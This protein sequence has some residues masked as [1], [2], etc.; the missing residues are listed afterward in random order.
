MDPFD[1][2]TAEEIKA[3]RG[4][5]WIAIVV[6]ILGFAAAAGFGGLYFLNYYEVRLTKES[7]G[8]SE[9]RYSEEAT[10]LN[11]TI[12]RLEGELNSKRDANEILT[13]QIKDEKNRAQQEKNRAENLAEKIETLEKT[14]EDL[15]SGDQGIVRMQAKLA[16]SEVRVS[17]LQEEIQRTRNILA[18]TQS[19][20][21]E[22]ANVNDKLEKD[23]KKTGTELR[24]AKEMLASANVTGAAR[25]VLESQLKD[26][27]KQIDDLKD[28][29]RK[30]EDELQRKDGELGTLRETIGKSGQ[31]TA[32]LQK[33]MEELSNRDREIGR[34]DAEI[35][36]L[37]KEVE[38]LEKK[39]DDYERETNS[40]RNTLAQR[41]DVSEQVKSLSEAL[42]G[43]DQIIK[44]KDEE[45]ATLKEKL[46][47]SEE[48]AEQTSESGKAETTELQK[49]LV[50]KTGFIQN[51]EKQVKNLQQ[52][53]K[54][55]N[56]L[57]KTE[58]RS[59]EK[60][61]KGEEAEKVKF[62]SS[63][64]RTS[65]EMSIQVTDGSVVPDKIDLDS[66]LG[67][68]MNKNSL[69]LEI[70]ASGRFG[71]MLDYQELTFSGRNVMTANRN[72]FNNTLNAGDTVDSEFYIQQPGLGLLA[73][74][75]ALHKSET[76]RIDLGLLLGGR[77]LKVN[78]RILD[79]TTGVK[80]TDTLDAPL[81]Y[82]G[83]KV[84]GTYRD[85]VSWSVQARTMNFNYGDYS[86]RNYVEGRVAFGF[87]LM[88]S[89]D[90]D[91]GYAYAN[92]NYKRLDKDTGE[93][94][95][96]KHTSEGPFF[97]VVLTF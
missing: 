47:T 39:N 66:D 25:D 43:R 48:T 30:N 15:R 79:R 84:S 57:L 23:L 11:E 3:M 45:M 37:A 72:F 53:N 19:R 4:T 80:S 86:L 2:M 91:F 44:K 26:K 42:A 55:I 52:E 96:S 94:F 28:K 16:E 5:S 64:W 32:E 1:R 87:N 22:A 18:N 6:A 61:D 93:S 50:E 54:D 41:G 63:I 71:F 29:L 13:Q 89:L 12:T 77:Y 82:V 70:V 20:L 51:L 7:A 33:A 59:I 65:N 68:A 36:S 60:V 69:M 92:T 67:H 35:E 83:L 76:R 49:Q 78:S 88:N 85:G 56:S 75:G 73:N 46:K 9:K 90:I 21:S 24:N 58:K 8:K 81:P 38:K 40:L 74:L 31:A 10:R 95:L 97:S 17:A 14:L 34:K 27:E 62:L